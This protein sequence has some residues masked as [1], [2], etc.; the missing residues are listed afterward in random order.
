MKIML[1]VMMLFGVEFWMA[2]VH[3]SQSET[4]FRRIAKNEIRHGRG[5][6]YFLKKE[7]LPNAFEQRRYQY[8]SG[9][10]IRGW[11]CIETFPNNVALIRELEVYGWRHKGEKAGALLSFAKLECA[12]RGA[13]KIEFYVPRQSSDGKAFAKKIGADVIESGQHDVLYTVENEHYG[14]LQRQDTLK[15]VLFGVMGFAG[16][17]MLWGLATK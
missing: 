12:R 11:L 3:C 10:N 5:A 6:H 1:W 13:K 17:G 8:E 2:N 16:L 14:R 4:S 7:S 15:R 9:K